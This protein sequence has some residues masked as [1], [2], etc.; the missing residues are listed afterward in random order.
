MKL[1]SIYYCLDAATNTHFQGFV[2]TFINTVTGE[3]QS[4]PYGLV[5]T[6][7]DLCTGA[8]TTDEVQWIKIKQDEDDIEGI[9]IGNRVLET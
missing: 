1:D 8:Y 2:A 7:S 4:L 5:N 9:V 6:G 3:K